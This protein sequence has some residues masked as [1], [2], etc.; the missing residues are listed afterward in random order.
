MGYITLPEADEFYKSG[1]Y[2]PLITDN[3]VGDDWYDI[4]E[5][6]YLVELIW[7]KTM[8]GCNNIDTFISQEF[9]KPFCIFF[10]TN[11]IEESGSRW[12]HLIA[13]EGKSKAEGVYLE[14][15]YRIGFLKKDLPDNALGT[16]KDELKK[17]DEEYYNGLKGTDIRL[18]YLGYVKDYNE[19]LEQ[20]D[21]YIEVFGGTL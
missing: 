11:L 3:S 10:T 5:Y 6:E 21:R 19:L 9:K 15:F 17:H 1:I 8:K 16:I 2:I 20:I 7:G 13:V 4:N 12:K 14:D 18:S